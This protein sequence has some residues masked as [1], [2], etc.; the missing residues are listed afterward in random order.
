MAGESFACIEISPL[1]TSSETQNTFTSHIVAQTGI[2]REQSCSPQ[3][4]ALTS[5]H[6]ET[7]S[8]VLD[9]TDRS[10]HTVPTLLGHTP[11]MAFITEWNSLYLCGGLFC[12]SIYLLLSSYMHPPLSKFNVR[13]IVDLAMFNRGIRITYFRNK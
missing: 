2:S 9:G 12:R 1:T 7:L 6:C 4:V 8:N 3:G 10:F 5:L 13:H 11:T